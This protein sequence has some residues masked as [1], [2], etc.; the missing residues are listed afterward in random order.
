M[1]LK[2]TVPRID[3][4]DGKADVVLDVEF[5]VEWRNSPDDEDIVTVL[6]VEVD[7]VKPHKGDRCHVSDSAFPLVL[8][9]L[10]N[11]PDLSDDIAEKC[12]EHARDRAIDRSHP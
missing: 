5:E 10:I 6:G 9:A 7:E 8:A 4:P 1:N 12:L 2:Y 11:D 3:F